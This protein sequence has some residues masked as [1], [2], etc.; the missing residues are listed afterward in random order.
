MNKK[1]GLE[2]KFARQYV[3]R[4]LTTSRSSDVTTWFRH[5]LYDALFKKTRLGRQALTARIGCIHT[6]RGSFRSTTFMPL[7]RHCT[8]LTRRSASRTAL[9]WWNGSR[10]RPADPPDDGSLGGSVTIK[11]HNHNYTN[12]LYIYC[13]AEIE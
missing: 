4:D 6:L 7:L 13:L 9:W 5:L 2:D 3:N 1:R 10:W 11:Y 8:L 12:I